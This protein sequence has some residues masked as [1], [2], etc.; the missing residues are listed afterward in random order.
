MNTTP[1]NRP[2]CTAADIKAIREDCIASMREELASGELAAC[3]K[4]ALRA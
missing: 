1:R 2:F 3:W 4:K